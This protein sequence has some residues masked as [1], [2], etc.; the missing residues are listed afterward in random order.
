MPRGRTGWPGRG[1]WGRPPT[2]VPTPIEHY[3][4]SASRSH[5]QEVLMKKADLIIDLQYG[6]TGKGLIAGYLASTRDYDL[7]INANMPN[8]G[9]TFIDEWGQVMVHKVLPNGVVG[10]NVRNVIIGPGS[11]FCLRQ[12]KRELNQLM[13]F[14]Y[15]NWTLLIH[16]NAVVLNDN[17]RT[18]EAEDE[19]LTK[20]GSTK[21]GSAAAMIHKIKRD[22]TNN[23]TAKE[24]FRND[25][26]WGPHLINQR[27]YL[28]VV[29]DAK[30]V[31]L[32]GAQ[33]Y[34]L[35][36]NAGFYP[37][38]TSRDCTPA[39]FMADM[40][41]PLPYLRRVIGTARLHPIR[42]GS[43]PGG[44]SGD[45]YPDQGEISWEEL[46]QVPELTTVTKRERRVFSWSQLQM[47]EAMM[48]CMPDEI[49]LNFCNYAP[50]EV[51]R[52]KGQIITAGSKA[53][54]RPEI[55][56]TGW[57]ATVNDV[58]EVKINRG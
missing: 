28:E 18:A 36:I 38:C 51:D 21:Q 50:N 22:P 31:L 14:G 15:T 1:A 24:L 58:R 3:H 42:V 12:L 17:H 11:V 49:F 9:H 41:V 53:G 13:S 45:C 46:G 35:G 27:E 37:F 40:G 19:S 55:L 29:R 30:N 39:R 52:V 56:Y 4:G 23:P 6:S 34:S 47:E 44:Y 33:G 8:A 10:K 32:E 5:N 16:E 2:Y 20:N 7:V 26:T 43:P 54:K 48:A 25:L 57:G